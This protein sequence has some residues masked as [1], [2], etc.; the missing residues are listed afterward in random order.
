MSDIYVFGPNNETNEYDTMGF[1]GALVPTSCTFT[2]KINGE[3]ALELNHPYDDFGRYASLVEGNIL[4]A[5]VPVI[6]T[7]EIQNGSCVTTVWT[8]KVKPLAQLTSKNQRTLYKKASGNSKK[9]IMKAGDIVTVVQ[10]PE[11]DNVR[12]KVKSN[13]GTGW[14]I[15]DGFELVT[16]HKLENNSSAIQEIKAPWTITEQYFRIYEM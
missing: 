4:V 3:S 6:T 16:E 2:Q 5:K 11:G 12:W 8:Y 7:P 13:Y 9:K 10:K 1:V 15:P 14:I